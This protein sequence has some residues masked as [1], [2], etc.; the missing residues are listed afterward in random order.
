MVACAR[1]WGGKSQCQVNLCELRP[2]C[3]VY[4]LSSGQQGLRGRGGNGVDIGQS[5]KESGN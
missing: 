2:V 5:R 3:L 4:I 1:G